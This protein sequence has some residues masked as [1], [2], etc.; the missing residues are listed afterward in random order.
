[1]LSPNCKSVAARFD[2]Q[3]NVQGCSGPNT[4]VRTSR[5]PHS[6]RVAPTCSPATTSASVYEAAARMRSRIV[7][8]C[9]YFAQ[10]TI[11]SRSLTRPVN[12]CLHVT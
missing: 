1:M 10:I 11:A 7:A 6:S 3:V 4:R 2:A 12:R 5:M 9:A 8:S